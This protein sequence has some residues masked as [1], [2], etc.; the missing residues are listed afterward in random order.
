MIGKPAGIRAAL[1]VIIILFFTSAQAQPLL[2]DMAGIS[3]KGVNFLTWTCQYDGIKSIAVQRSSDSLMNFT[4]V[5]YVKNMKKGVQAFVDGHP[6]PGNNYYE[7]LIVFS[8]D[9]SWTS[10]RIK[11]YVDSTLIKNRHIKLPS[12]DSLQKYLTTTVGN[13]K[14]ADDE[15]KKPGSNTAPKNTTNTVASQPSLTIDEA[16]PYSPYGTKT[17]KKKKT[18]IVVGSKDIDVVTSLDSSIKRVMVSNDSLVKK[19]PKIIIKLTTDVTELDPY[20][21]VK[22]QYVFPDDLTG[23]INITLPDVK[24]HSYSMK[25]LNDKNKVVM[26]IPRLNVSPII[27]DKR[28][29]RQSGLYKFTIKRDNKE[30]ETGMVSV[31]LE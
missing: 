4:T 10:N 6:L 28:N 21:Y 11:L 23:N 12:N 1:T 13:N 20:S 30:F 24:Y 16:T 3:D 2:P 9:L 26:D 25:I 14:D 17:A 18:I 8:S 27:M 7:L 15:D 19:Q 31:S 22:S 5:G 29:F